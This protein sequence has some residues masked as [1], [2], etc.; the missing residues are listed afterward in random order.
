[1]HILSE[2]I[3]GMSANKPIVVIGGGIIGASCAYHLSR[4]GRSV[5]VIERESAVGVKCSYG[6]CGLITPSHALPLPRPGVI[7]QAIKWMGD[8]SSPFYIKPRFNTDLMTWL[9]RFALACN[10]TTMERSAASLLPLSLI[11]ARDYAEFVRVSPHGDSIGYRADPGLCVYS[12]SGGFERGTALMGML[13]ELGCPGYTLTASEVRD[14]EPALIGDIAGATRFDV[15]AYAE[16]NATVNGLIADAIDHGC[17]VMRNTEV[18]DFIQDDQ[19]IAGVRTNKGDIDCDE[20]ILATGS[21]S[22][23]LGRKLDLRI[24][25]QPAKGYSMT[26]DP[27]DPMPR[28][29]VLLAETKVVV[30]PRDGCVRIGGTLELVG[31]DESITHQRVQAVIA[32]ARKHYNIPE[33]IHIRETWRGLRPCTPHGLPIIGRAGRWTN[34]IVATGHAMQGL[35]YG[36]GTGRLVAEL[37]EGTA[38]SMDVAPLQLTCRTGDA[39][40]GR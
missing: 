18:T 27:F 29:P 33:D 21:W 12:T 10:Q 28:T 8:S 9:V 32:G 3:G 4:R 38:T 19:Q 2:R 15:D 6:N 36:I 37:V 26:V 24:P 25:V 7:Q 23:V 16:P 14:L 40:P 31:L 11:S 1:M 34:V 13:K 39:L 35:T 22:P 20:V 17:Q 5:L 30:T